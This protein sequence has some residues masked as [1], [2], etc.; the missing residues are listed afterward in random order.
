MSKSS[1]I[2]RDLHL[3]TFADCYPVGQRI[4]P[5]LQPKVTH[6]DVQQAISEVG[7]H[8]Y[9]LLI[10]AALLM[11]VR[12]GISGYL[13]RTIT[14]LRRLYDHL[15]YKNNYL[16]EDLNNKMQKDPS[17]VT[18]QDKERL[19]TLNV[20][21][22]ILGDQIDATFKKLECLQEAI[23][24]IEDLQSKATAKAAI[25]HAYL[26]GICSELDALD[27]YFNINTRFHSA[28][29]HA[30]IIRQRCC[31]MRSHDPEGEEN[32]D[33]E[34]EDLADVSASSCLRRHKDG[35][36][37]VEISKPPSAT[38][39][40]KCDNPR[41]RST[42]SKSEARLGQGVFATQT[43]SPKHKGAARLPRKPQPLPRYSLYHQQELQRLRA[44][45]R[46]HD[47]DLLPSATDFESARDRKW[48]QPPTPP[49]RDA[50]SIIVAS[51]RKGYGLDYASTSS[52]SS[53]QARKERSRPQVNK[54]DSFQGPTVEG[55]QDTKYITAGSCPIDSKAH[56]DEQTSSEDN[57]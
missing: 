3:K 1:E 9:G 39:T 53:E 30:Q 41:S 12:D 47:P 36:Q 10:S 42:E 18:D 49:P 22:D 44:V 19:E 15:K 26:V 50:S 28:D 54:K 29:R 43:K 48:N 55:S 14:V 4:W 56:I 33:L 57:A 27:S 2:E 20:S 7:P 40:P 21:R 24:E 6:E 16:A 37:G 34:T 13:S 51:E 8:L 45:A 46:Q 35:K 17:Q 52:E 5:L 23:S 25:R 11:Q 32:E 31:W 38:S